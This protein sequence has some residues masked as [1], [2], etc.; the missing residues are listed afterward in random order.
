MTP[1]DIGG[2]IWLVL[3]LGLIGIVALILL[4]CILSLIPRAR[5]SLDHWLP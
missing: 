5:R 4:L 1:A 3:Q 2:L